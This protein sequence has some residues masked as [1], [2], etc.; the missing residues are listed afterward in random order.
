MD[1]ADV[2]INFIKHVEALVARGFTRLEGRHL[3]ES[4]TLQESSRKVIDRLKSP[5]ARVAIANAFAQLDPEVEE[6]LVGELQFIIA[7]I[8]IMEPDGEHDKHRKHHAIQEVNDEHDQ[9]VAS[10]A[11]TGKDSLE[12]ILGK[13]LP[14]WLK[15]R[16]KILNEILSIVFK[17]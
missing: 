1:P 10:A 16:L 11:K 8:Q 15:N 5:S 14:K 4:G 3:Q 6:A 17:I 2:Y 9:D 12:S 13:F 7:N